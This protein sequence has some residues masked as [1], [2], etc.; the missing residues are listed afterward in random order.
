MYRQA[1][2]ANAGNL[3]N[4]HLAA[5]RVICL[6]LYPGLEQDVIEVILGI[7]RRYAPK[8]TAA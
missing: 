4:A 5:E 3:P 2:G 7:I 8:V 6:P 1:A